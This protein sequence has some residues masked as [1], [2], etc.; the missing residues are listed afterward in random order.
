MFTFMVLCY[1]TC[2]QLEDGRILSAD[3]V[4]AKIQDKVGIPPDQQRLIFAARGWAH[5]VG[6][7]RP[8]GASDFHA[9]AAGLQEVSVLGGVLETIDHA[10][11]TLQGQEGIPP[12]QQRLNFADKLFEDGRTLSVD[13]VKATLRPSS[14]PFSR[15]CSLGTLR[16]GSPPFRRQAAWGWTQVVWY[17]WHG[18]KPG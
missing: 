17:H 13:T 10:A 9:Q 11:A 5:A 18:Q 6:L 3:H 16:T 12:N 2:K 14:A 8:G 4:K 1:S 15:A 7:H